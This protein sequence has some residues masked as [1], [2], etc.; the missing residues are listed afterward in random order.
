ML[1]KV[2]RQNTL[3]LQLKINKVLGTKIDEV[4]DTQFKMHNTFHLFTPNRTFSNT[5]L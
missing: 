1:P 2:D 5:L 3:K 4:P